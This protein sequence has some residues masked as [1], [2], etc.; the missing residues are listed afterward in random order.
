M[1]W[2]LLTLVQRHNFIVYL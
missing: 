2:N 1:P